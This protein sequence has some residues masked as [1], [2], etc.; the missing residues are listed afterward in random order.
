[1]KKILCAFMSLLL[2][3]SVFSVAVSAIEETTL[4][5]QEE[6]TTVEATE[7]TTEETTDEDTT[8]EPTTEE[9]TT[10]PVTPPSTYET[11][12]KVEAVVSG[13]SLT[14]ECDGEANSYKV[15]RRKAGESQTKL[16]ATVENK[17]FVDK[18]VQNNT[19][20]KYHVESIVDSKVKGVSEGILI[21]Y[22]KAVKIIDYRLDTTGN[23]WV[24]FRW[25]RVEGATRYDVYCRSAGETEYRKVDSAIY[26]NYINCVTITSGYHRFAVVAVDGNYRGAID[27]NGPLFKHFEEPYMNGFD[28]IENGVKIKWHFCDEATGYRVYRRASGEKYYTYLCTTQD[29]KYEDTTV[30]NG[31]YYRYVVRAV[32]GNVIGPYDTRG[33]FFQ[34]ITKAK[35][36]AVANATDGVYVRWT[37]VVGAKKYAILRREAGGVYSYIA[38][39]DASKGNKYKDTSTV[40]LEYYRYSVEAFSGTNHSRGYDTK[41]LVIKH[42]PLGTTW[43]TAS[44]IK[45]NNFH[46]SK[47]YNDVKE[48]KLE[49]WQKLDSQKV[50]GDNKQF[51]SEF[52]KTM[53]T[54]FN[55]PVNTVINDSPELQDYY[56]G[57]VSSKS[58][59]SA[60]MTSNGNYYTITIVLKDQASP[61]NDRFDGI[62]D[63]SQ[64]YI[65][66]Q[67]LVDELYDEDLI[68]YGRANSM[69]KNFT[70]VSTFSKKDGK[71][72]SVTHSCENVTASMDLTF[73]NGLGK[74]KYNAQF[75]TYL[76]YTNFK[77]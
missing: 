69:Y 57:G 30:K 61:E 24:G 12:L 66:Y 23:P 60:K 15:Y 51:A 49:H 33:V 36:E 3:L 40:P 10:E 28:F 20:Y 29:N 13:V 64:N 16:I 19:Y 34:Y 58:V 27:T 56:P 67:G 76:R 22:L 35:L 7:P 18:N 31:V 39:V 9:P 62:R 71:L 77:Y 47:T 26:P 70:V 14:W 73:V 63:T 48:Y 50:T 65:D 17:N 72:V 68:S 32:Y 5:A 54:M 4:P 44:I 53:R 55:S 74:L 41:G 43:N 37:P 42:T 75:D 46:T 52:D 2:I 45:Y 25:E 38:T 6:Q 59:K 11:K 21:K 8:N 1:M